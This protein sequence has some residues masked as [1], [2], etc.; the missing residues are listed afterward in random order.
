MSDNETTFTCTF[1]PKT[2]TRLRIIRKAFNEPRSS[3]EA[4]KDKL[5]CW[6]ETPVGTHFR[7]VTCGR[8]GDLDALRP[9]GK[10]GQLG[11][12]AGYGRHKIWRSLKADNSATLRNALD[13]LPDSSYFDA[14]FTAIATAGEQPP[15]DIPDM[16]ELTR[17][18]VAWM[19]VQDLMNAGKP[20]DQ[21]IAAIEA[22]DLSLKRYNRL[23]ELTASYPSIKN[24]V[25]ELVLERKAAE[26]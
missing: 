26:Q 9:G 25:T 1:H 7:H 6:L 5:L 16:E 15:R 21:A 20:E 17:F 19:N 13:R 12:S 8:N 18:A 3:L 2:E 11:G 10:S 24:T 14:D 23:A 4:D 22:E